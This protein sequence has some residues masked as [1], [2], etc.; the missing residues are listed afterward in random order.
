M[1]GCALHLRV[2]VPARSG[3]RRMHGGQTMSNKQR[4]RSNTQRQ[5]PA[6][7]LMAETVLAGA[8][9]VEAMR[10]TI[11]NVLPVGPWT[12]LLHRSLA[13]TVVTAVVYLQHKCDG[14]AVHLQC[15]Q[16]Q[17][18]TGSLADVNQNSDHS[19]MC[20]CSAGATCGWSF[21]LIEK[22]SDV[23]HLSTAAPS[24]P[25]SAQPHD[26]PVVELYLFNS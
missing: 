4:L 20:S 25:D 11:I 6:W 18:S 26:E 1:C 22:C 14:Q 2:L 3:V 15:F 23:S 12:P 19:S 7:T 5:A 13:D 24:Q 21:F 9:G 17:K 16:C 10:R 8:V